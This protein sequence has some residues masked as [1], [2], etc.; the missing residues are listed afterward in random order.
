[1]PLIKK[2]SNIMHT[3]APESSDVLH[4]EVANLQG[5][6]KRARQEDSFAFVNALDEEQCR[7][8]G[9]MFLVCDGMGGMKDGKLA[10][11]KAI[12]CMLENFK[13]MDRRGM[14]AEQLHESVL[15]AAEEVR[16]LL[17]SDGGSTLVCGI[18][19]NEKLY[20]A[21]V[22]D[23]YLY[24]LRSGR[25]FRMNTEH[26]ICHLRYLENIRDGSFDKE[27]AQQDP[28]A[29]ALSNYLGMPA[30][31]DVDH[32]VKPLNLKKGDIIFACS[33]GVG[34]VLN[35]EEI[36]NAFCAETANECCSFIEKAIIGHNV[37]YQDNYTAVV[38]R[39]F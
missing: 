19:L 7:K 28:E 6:G 23:S 10:S 38:V 32:S 37:Q 11:E 14:I 20:F 21:S 12:Q 1:M 18:I 2:K 22:G 39:C 30:V 8:F 26:N 3:A 31:P 13:A 34:G 5:I 4:Y 24:L 33:D 16:V 36:L 27:S 9:M 25:L 35:E 17:D 15:R 29:P